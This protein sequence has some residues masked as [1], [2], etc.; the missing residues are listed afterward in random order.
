M[1]QR[2][3]KEEDKS[4]RRTSILAAARRLFARQP[5]AAI[6]MDRVAAAAG[7]AKGTLY[8]YYDTRERLFLA[9]L[10][11]QLGAWFAALEADLASS[12][13]P[14]TPA[15]L[16]RL[17]WETLAGRP[18]LVRLLSL[19]ESVLEHNINAETAAAFKKMLLER[20]SAAGA[21]VEQRLAGLRAG[22]GL[23]LLLHL[24]ALLT[25]LAQMADNP[26]VIREVLERNPDLAVF[27]LDLGREFTQAGA[28]LIAGWPRGAP[29]SQF[30]P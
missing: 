10:E 16:A 3:R 4:S 18:Q 7:L 29:S 21:L 5:Y 19:M 17:I 9:L 23:H 30:K 8:L 12:R 24:R 28:A 22:D 1:P 20:M 6:S 15:D 14:L 11:E 27:R 2:A 13:R 25:G 26:P